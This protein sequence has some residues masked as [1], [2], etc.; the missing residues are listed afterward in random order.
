MPVSKNHYLSH[1]PLEILQWGPPRL[2]WCMLFEHENQQFKRAA[3]HSNFANVLWSC[4]NSK[5]RGLCLE[6]LHNKPRDVQPSGEQIMS[7]LL[8]LEVERWMAQEA[9]RYGVG[10]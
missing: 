5:A 7:E 3:M 4:A 6:L 10:F 2:Y 9:F 1:L 8:E